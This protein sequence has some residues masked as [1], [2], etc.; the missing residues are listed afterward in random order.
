MR[1]LIDRKGEQFAYFE[2]EVLYTLEGDVTGRIEGEFIVDTGRKSHV[3]HR[4][5]R[6]LFAR[7][8]RNNRISRQRSAGS[9]RA[10]KGR[11]DANRIERWGTISA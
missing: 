8:Q 10:L 3:A 7:Q 11:F 4:G 5:G 2:G 9:L 1:G 6:C